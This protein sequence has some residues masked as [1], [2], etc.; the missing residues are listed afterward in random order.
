[1][2]PTRQQLVIERFFDDSGGMQLV[3][4]APY[5]ARLN[6]GFGLALRK[7][8]CVT[9]DFELQAAANDDALILS[10]GPQH[11]FPL[12]QVMRYLRADTVGEVLQQAVLV[13]PFAMFTSRWRWNLNRSLAVLRWKGGRRNPPAIQ[14]MEAED[15]MAAVF[16]TAAACQENATGPLEV[17][18]H[19]LVRQTL[20]DTMTE[21]LDLD[22]LQALLT[23]IE[24]GRV[25]VHTRDTTEPS[26]LCHELLTGRPYTFL[27]DAPAEERRTRAVNVRRGLPVDLRDIGRV[28]P[29]AIERVR[30]EIEPEPRSADELHDLLL[31]LVLTRA[32]PGWRSL[33]DE[34]AA[35]GRAVAFRQNDHYWWV[36][37]ERPADVAALLPGTPPTTAEG[38]AER[39]AREAVRGRLELRGPATPEQLVELTGLSPGTVA[40]AL[41][42]LEASGFALQGQFSDPEGQSIEWCSRRLL[43]RIH[44]YSQKRRRS[45]IEPVSAQDYV[46]FLHRWQHVAPGTRLSG[47]DGLLAVIEQL[48]GW[49][50]PAGAWE[51][52]LLARRLD[53]YR[54]SLLDQRCHAGDVVWA[55]LSL[56]AQPDADGGA[57]SPSR[58][59]PISLCGRADLDWLLV[60]C[61]GPEYSA[62]EPTAGGLAEILDV[63]RSH[64]ARFHRELAADTGRLASDIERGLWDGVARGLLT[65]DGFHAVRSLLDARQ[66]AALQVH[67]SPLRRRRSLRRGAAPSRAPGEGRWALVPGPMRVDEPDELAEA[68]AEQLLSRWG[69]V[70][71]DVVLREHL[72]VPWREV[73]W[74]FRRLEA[75]GVI[76][77]G[78]FVHGFSGEQ[79]ASPEAV[80]A[81]RTVRRTPPNGDEITLSAADP[82]NLT[83]IVVPGARVPSL[84]NRTITWRDGLPVHPC[85]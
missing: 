37:T 1:M 21:A 8:F 36:A 32:V 30:S 52:Q 63:L 14:R 72:N 15:L 46:R 79:Y 66:V 39:G 26:P 62:E 18:D 70:F 44:V 68:V 34:L 74:A 29:A 58:A 80:D 54:P 69:I 45:E 31:S 53:G 43:Q 40:I 50:A 75:R 55:R 73:Q 77:G 10:L 42:A 12:D 13:P 28:D 17:P 61:R 33:F 60:A 9:F 57:R 35:R 76:R 49:E 38:D 16:P 19:P 83:G 56:P 20:H 64:G 23:E 85:G 7:R 78:R 22:G 4:H 25:V 11:S 47:P 82:L 71:R 6:R 5:G 59:T 41:A 67:E 48:Q 3:V 51:T 84:G 2:V 27:D 81:L 65:A 24:A